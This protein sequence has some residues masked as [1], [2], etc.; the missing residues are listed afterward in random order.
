MKP[1]RE[2]DALVAEK[3]M[4]LGEPKHLLMP[5]GLESLPVVIYTCAN[6]DHETDSRT[7]VEGCEYYSPYSTDIRRAWEVRRDAARA[8]LAPDSHAAIVLPA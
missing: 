5:C 4:G 7:D 8:W 3:V 1:G 6:C 2:L